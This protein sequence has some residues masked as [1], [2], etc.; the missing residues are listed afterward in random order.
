[1]QAL[2]VGWRGAPQITLLLPTA[3]V[4]ATACSP[5]QRQSA[6]LQAYLHAA[7]NA[8]KTAILIATL[9]AARDTLLTDWCYSWAPLRT[10]NTAPLLAALQRLDALHRGSL[11]LPVDTPAPQTPL[12]GSRVQVRVGPPPQAAR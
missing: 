1:L 3:A 11:A 6:A 2:E 12:P 10:G 7:F 4:A 5:P 8:R 9:V